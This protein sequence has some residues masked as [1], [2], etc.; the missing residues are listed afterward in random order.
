MNGEHAVILAAEDGIHKN[1]SGPQ[2]ELKTFVTSGSRGR[3]GWG[4]PVRLLHPSPP[5]RLV[6]VRVLVERYP[7]QGT[8]SRA[9]GGGSGGQPRRLPPPAHRD[10]PSC[11]A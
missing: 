2:G 11:L 10:K 1:P 6:D 8:S 9:G 5:R 7:F 4:Y 3:M